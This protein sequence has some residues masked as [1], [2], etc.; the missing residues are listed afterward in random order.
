MKQ[1]PN[2]KNNRHERSLS[3]TETP[4]VSV[5]KLNKREKTDHQLML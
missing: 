2:V 4:G 1:Q 3:Q 5:M